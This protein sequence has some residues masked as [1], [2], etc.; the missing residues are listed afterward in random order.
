MKAAIPS[1]E[2][3]STVFAVGEG[4]R[5]LDKARVSEQ[6]DLGDTEAVV[7]YVRQLPLQKEHHYRLAISL[8]SLAIADYPQSAELHKERA[9]LHFQ[10]REDLQALEDVNQAI[11][12]GASEDPES[13]ILR[14]D[15][16]LFNGRYEKAALDFGRA[17]NL[18]PQDAALLL[19]ARA[20]ARNLAKDNA[21][22]L[23]DIAAAL[24]RDPSELSAYIACVKTYRDL[25][26]F[27]QAA[28]CYGMGVLVLPIT[29]LSQELSDLHVL[30]PG[31]LWDIRPAQPKWFHGRARDEVYDA[32]KV[33]LAGAKIGRFHAARDLKVAMEYEQRLQ[34]DLEGFDR[35]KKLEAAGSPEEAE[36]EAAR[37]DMW[38]IAAPE[39]RTRTQELLKHVQPAFDRTLAFGS[40]SRGNN[41]DPSD[42]RGLWIL[43]PAVETIQ[44]ERSVY[45]VLDQLLGPW[46]WFYLQFGEKEDAGGA[47]LIVQEAGEERK[48]SLSKKVIS[49]APRT[50][51][52]VIAGGEGELT[53]KSGGKW[54]VL[55]LSVIPE[56]G[57]SK[58]EVELSIGGG[59]PRRYVRLEFYAGNDIEEAVAR[60]AAFQIMQGTYLDPEGRWS[61]F[62]PLEAR[63]GEVP[64]RYSVALSFEGAEM[65]CDLISMDF[66]T[67]SKPPIIAGIGWRDGTLQLLELEEEVVDGRKRI[68]CRSENAL[69]F[70]P[71]TLP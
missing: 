20:I 25:Q 36:N 12:F 23:E 64:I 71:A 33:G 34:A 28:W 45:R 26:S 55:R 7:R 49:K 29:E 65:Q 41:L 32:G 13:F 69:K 44:A 56:S 52:L 62:D 54:P 1:H 70:L 8:L 43:K 38:G 66:P 5:T 37:L 53:S 58:G 19:A 59:P 50:S 60:W 6:V 42:L 22:A 61:Y 16:Y 51:T 30:F 27:G 46:G 15:L 57:N 11:R 48:Y 17:L 14:G 24:E 63:V 40:L 68:S 31:G 9:R 18:R 35:L 3:I 2:P 47:T 21:R 67:L 39:T 4:R 10:L